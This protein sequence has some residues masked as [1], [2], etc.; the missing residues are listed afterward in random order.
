M[1]QNQQQCQTGWATIQALDA[2]IL[3]YRDVIRSAHVF[4]LL[5]ANRV[6]DTLAA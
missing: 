4:D 2:I 3:N 5:Q 6:G 1:T